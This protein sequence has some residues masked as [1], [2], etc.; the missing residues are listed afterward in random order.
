VNPE[1]R[2]CWRGSSGY[3]EA[4]R[5]PQ[6]NRDV[7]ERY[8]VGILV[9]ESIDDCVAA[10]GL[11]RSRGLVVSVRAGGHSWGCWGLREGTL[12]VDVGGLKELSLRDDDIAIVGPGVRGGTELMPFLADRGRSFPGG[13]CP[14]VAVSGY[15]LNGGQGWNSRM[16][17]WARQSVVAIDV[18][19]ADGEIVHA[20]ESENA[21]LLWAARGAGPGFFGIVVRWY[22]QTYP[23]PRRPSQSTVVWSMDHLDEV[24]R[25][26]HEV[27]PGWAP[28]CEPAVFSVWGP[29]LPW[30]V[31]DGHVLM[32]NATAMA[33]S[34]E[35][36]EHVFAPLVG[37]PLV[38]DATHA[39]FGQPTSLA[40]V[41]GELALQMPEGF[42]YAADCLWT[43]A[44]PDELLPLLRP[45]FT[46]LP[47]E[48]SF[49]LWNGWDPPDRPDMAFSLEGTV[50]L[51][52]Y[53]IWDDPALA[54]RCRDFVTSTMKALEP[55]GKGAYLGDAD[56][57][58]RP[59]RFMA[60]ANFARLESIRTRRDP[61]GLFAS[62]EVA[63]GGVPNQRP[64]AASPT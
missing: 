36:V 37:C 8:P 42:H 64:T 56:P 24:L 1:D 26:A 4:R 48:R 27:L 12:L 31:G 14:T 50:Y 32:L 61:G 49:T 38:N 44:G 39:E 30:P 54:D 2:I 6:F 57:V 19:T 22:L 46:T 23:A 59:D 18:V 13:H 7:P 9:A 21:D 34:A 40:E 41:Y 55:C 33:D 15:L 45:A 10:V 43:D 53:A 51:A 17:G 20:S 28:P 16:W 11:A 25:W 63:P 47:T 52:T 35:E 3:E 62:W 29:S 5:S 58:R 60:P